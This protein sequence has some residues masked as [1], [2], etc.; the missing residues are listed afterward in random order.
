MV[1]LIA[2][3]FV[4]WSLGS[5]LPPK[6]VSLS[7]GALWSLAFLIFDILLIVFCLLIFCSYRFS[8]IFLSSMQSHPDLSSPH[9]WLA[10][11]LSRNDLV[12]WYY[13]IFI[14]FSVPCSLKVTSRFFVNDFLIL[15]ALLIAT[16]TV[17]SPLW[18]IKAYHSKP[19]PIIG[20]TGFFSISIIVY[21]DHFPLLLLILRCYLTFAISFLFSYLAANPVSNPWKTAD[22]SSTGRFR[23]WP[24]V[25]SMP[26]SVRIVQSNQLLCS[27]SSIWRLLHPF[28]PPWQWVVSTR[29]C[30]L[31][32]DTFH[33]HQYQFNYSV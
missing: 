16:W 6:A 1:P 4:E 18:A 23:N 25:A 29:R 14:I 2:V 27:R 8:S 11:C 22:S 21:I 10:T 31:L 20:C 26:W 28:A 12:Q 5:Y 15:T 30:H 24:R 7:L 32:V 3:N 9:R 13:W 17:T 33:C 19:F